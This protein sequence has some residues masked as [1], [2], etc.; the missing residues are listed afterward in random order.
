[1][2]EAQNVDM[3]PNV[4]KI[5][6]NKK[7]DRKVDSSSLIGQASEM[8]G[9]SAS[10]E[11]ALAPLNTEATKM[12]LQ[13][14]CENTKIHVPGK[15]AKT[16]TNWCENSMIWVSWTNKYLQKHTILNAL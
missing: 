5:S 10:C 16:I 6:L 4:S 15:D 14:D 9:F 2:D 12:E 8:T 1:M 11:Y 7:G 13:V 3:D